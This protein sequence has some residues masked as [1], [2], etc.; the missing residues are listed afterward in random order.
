MDQD[1][2]H[3]MEPRAPPWAKLRQQGFATGHH[4]P[5]DPATT[6][7][8]LAG[9]VSGPPGLSVDIVGDPVTDEIINRSVSL[10]YARQGIDAQSCTRFPEAD[11][12]ITT[13]AG[14]TTP[15]HPLLLAAIGRLQGDG[16][17][18]T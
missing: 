2:S 9:D 12:V 18:I 6:N 15:L 11:G 1:H 3:R 14:E 8:D 7:S 4:G 13:K 16:S 5:N 10:P 17:C